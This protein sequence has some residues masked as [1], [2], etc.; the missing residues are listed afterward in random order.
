MDTVYYNSNNILHYKVYL[1]L[2]FMV[3]GQYTIRY[4]LTSDLASHVGKY[5][6]IIIEHVRKAR[7]KRFSTVTMNSSPPK[8]DITK[9]DFLDTVIH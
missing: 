4:T 6:I 3:I 2:L 9:P 1:S 5:N 7:K 8:K